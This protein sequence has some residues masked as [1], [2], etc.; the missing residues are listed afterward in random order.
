MK[1]IPYYIMTAAL[2]IFVGCGNN[3][4]HSYSDEAE[5]H[6]V[7]EHS[8]DGHDHD[9]DHDHDHNHDAEHAHDH[10]HSHDAHTEESHNHAPGIIEFTK[11]Q[12]DAAE[13]EIET[14]QPASFNAV[15]R[16]SGEILPAQGDE[17]TVVATTS[18]IVTLGSGSRILPGV[19]VSKGATIA[20]ISSEEM[21]AGDPVAK[22]KAE[23]DA[24]EKAFE[25]AKSLVKVNAISQKSYDQAKKDY[26]TAKSSYEA[27]KGKFG[28]KG[29]SV[30]SPMAGYITQVIVNDGDYVE[31]G[32]PI[33]VVSQNNRLQLR[34]DLPEK[35]WSSANRIYSANFKPSYASETFSLKN[36]DGRLISAGRTAAKGTFY[37]PVIF[38]FNNAGNFV[39]GAFCDIY[40]IEGQKDNVI[41]V[42]ET[43]LTEEQGV[44]F[45]YLKV[46]ETEYKKQEVK[47]GESDGIRREILVGLHEGDIVVTKGAMQVK[48]ASVKG[49]IPGHTHNH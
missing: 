48:L 38:E 29:L 23:F 9:H 34:A 1:H 16:T 42:P 22:A 25:R 46:C 39:P 40:L 12:A 30:V 27:Y 3:S 41:S 7:H 11:A 8:H 2:A 32:Q 19:K 20:V 45:V 24:A 33:A 49:S 5:E 4:N 26:E 15:I 6:E 47:I 18:G 43:A 36:H 14:V 31:A 37:I 21:A 35:Y 44:Y 17:K 28:E 13:L 10:G